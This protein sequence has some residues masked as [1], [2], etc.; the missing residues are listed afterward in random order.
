MVSLQRSI[1]SGLLDGLLV[2]LNLH[3]VVMI[4]RGN[5][6]DLCGCNNLGLQ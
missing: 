6:H 3:D 5:V 4:G 2:K 1:V